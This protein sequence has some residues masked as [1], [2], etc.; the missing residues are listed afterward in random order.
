MAPTPI[1][2][3]FVDVIETTPTRSGSVNDSRK[4]LR[5][6]VLYFAAVAVGVVLAV[7]CGAY[8]V[9][10][11]FAVQDAAMERAFKLPLSS[12]ALRRMADGETIHVTLNRVDNKNISTIFQVTA[13]DLQMSR[14]ELLRASKIMNDRM[15]ASTQGWVGAA[16]R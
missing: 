4:K 3:V 13:E 5:P 2:P 10:D 11:S 9:I 1:Y 12:Q 8:S 15:Q 14:E 7:L 16:S 6:G